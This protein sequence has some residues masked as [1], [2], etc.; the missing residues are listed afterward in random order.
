MRKYVVTIKLLS[1]LHLGA[2]HEDVVVDA[3]AVHDYCGMPY[4]PGKRL[5][6]LLYESALEMAEISNGEWFT[7]ADVKK[8]FAQ[9]QEKADCEELTA[10]ESGII[11]EDLHLPEYEKLCRGWQYLNNEF[12][13][14]F[15]PREVWES[16]TEL[17]YQAAIDPETG[18][19]KATSLHNMRVV[20]AD[21]AFTGNLSLKDDTKTNQ[22]IIEKALLNLRYAG[23]KRNR[24]CG[25]IQCSFQGGPV[26]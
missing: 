8:L 24:G 19:T 2:G 21:I 5:K 14:I 9:I 17:R 16:Y 13:G 3:E 12:N 10:E 6:G 23:A 1:P 7:V 18:T 11:V 20:D 26:K 22:D 15:T 25:H 4:F